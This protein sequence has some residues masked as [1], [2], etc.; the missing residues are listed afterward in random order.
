MASEPIRIA[1]WSGPRNISTAL[2]RAWDARPDTVVCD[3]PLYAHYLS[4]TGRD[5]PG[6]DEVIAHHETCWRRVVDRLLGPV[7]EDRRIFYQKHMAH[8]LLPEI[9]LDWIG[10]LTN[11]LL[12]RD[13]GEMITSLIKFIDAPSAEETGLPQQTRLFDLVHETTGAAPPIVDARDILGQPAVMLRRLCEAVGVPYTDAMLSWAAGRRS[14]DG[15]WARHWY[16]AVEQSTGFAP[17]RPKA[18]DVPVRLH[19]LLEECR[20]LYD[21]LYESRLR[22]E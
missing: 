16:A 3:E 20:R 15:I 19:G 14:T 5:H 18:E 11:C 4:Q 6:R 17:Y 22:P 12:I 2:M 9:E 10:G 1:M 13:P 7:P 21:R 8:H